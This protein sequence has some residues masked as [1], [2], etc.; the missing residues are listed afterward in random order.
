MKCAIQIK[1]LLILIYRA[2]LVLIFNDADFLSVEDLN[3]SVVQ[4]PE[5]AIITLLKPSSESCWQTETE[6]LREPAE[7]GWWYEI[8]V[9]KGVGTV[10][11]QPEGTV[12]SLHPT[13]LLSW[14]DTTQWG[15]AARHPLCFHAPL[16]INTPPSSPNNTYTS[17]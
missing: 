7:L 14:K 16:S 17:R 13:Q 2:A 10:I 9:V 12:G 15:T 3:L 11:K 4:E 5:Q 6:A 8:L 1:L